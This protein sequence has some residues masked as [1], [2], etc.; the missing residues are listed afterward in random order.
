MTTTST[1]PASPNDTKP[2]LGL[3]KPAATETKA[4]PELKVSL[5]A[6][7]S[8]MKLDPRIAR[9]KL[10]IAVREAKKFPRTGEGAQAP[11]GMGMAEG[12]AR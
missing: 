4:T 5:K 9:E 3:G 12:I 2:T 7:C 10:R 1:K 8:E 11:L 6:I